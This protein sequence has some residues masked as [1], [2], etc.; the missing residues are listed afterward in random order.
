MA[1]RRMFSKQ[2]IDTDAFMDM[3]LS[4]QCLYFHL[5]MR[6]DDDGFV[7]NPKKIMR[8]VGAQDDDYKV[9][10]GKRFV[11]PFES[12]VCVIK[13]W[14]IHN[15]IRSDRYNS[16]NWTKEKEQLVIDEQTKKYRLTKPSKDVIPDGNQLEPQ[17]RLGKV[18][19]KGSSNEE[20]SSKKKKNTQK[21][22]PKKESI[23]YRVTNDCADLIKKKLGTRPVIGDKEMKGIK[24]ALSHISEKD[25]YLMVEDACDN[26]YAEKYN[27]SLNA[28]LSNNQLS[29]Y[30]HENT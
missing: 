13:H 25:I 24:N 14:L 29:K 7:P 16:T 30:I 12:G 6:A 17:V 22:Q 5:V 18:R 21:K 9:L 2:I 3:S 26:G 15:L 20:H 4:A 1:N 8:M 19:K 28:I 11:I 27:L 23:P 10:I